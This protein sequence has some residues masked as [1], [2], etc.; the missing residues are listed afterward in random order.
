M[1]A[2]RA[3]VDLDA[4]KNNFEVIKRAAGGAGIIAMVKA[5]AYGHGMITVG[6]TLQ[7]LG[8]DALGVA[9][10]DE[11]IVL[12]NSGVD[13]PIIVLTPN[14][15]HEADSIVAYGCTAVACTYEQVARLQ[16]AALAAQ[17]V[18]DV[19]LYV[20]TGMHREGFLVSEAF[21]A[22][23]YISELSNVKL[24]GACTHFATSNEPQSPFYKQQ[25]Q[26][27]TEVLLEIKQVGMGLDVVHVANTDAVVYDENSHFTHV[28]P[29]LALFGYSS[30]TEFQN[31]NLLPVMSLVSTV[32]ALRTIQPGESVSYGR[33]FIAPKTMTIATIPVGYGDGYTRRQL[34]KA[35]CII[36]K[37]LVPVVGWICMDECMADVTGLDVAIGDPVTLLGKAGD[38]SVT[39]KD[40]ADWSDTIRYEIITAVSGRIPRIFVGRTWNELQ[41]YMDM[42]V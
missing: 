13:V 35:H 26:Q 11:A 24:S 12:R 23:K 22:A 4:L 6:R 15:P 16:E 42:N 33:K 30:D 36:Q 20:D 14:D 31:E 5:N 32:I 2:T 25:L 41:A 37:Q 39:A 17:K 7:M 8:V 9:Y 40:L 21:S 27:F 19:H 18:V 1:R 34:G 38:K 28:R 10:V 29:G 3:I